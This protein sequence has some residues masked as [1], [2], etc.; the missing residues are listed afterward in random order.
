MCPFLHVLAQDVADIWFVWF[1]TF[2]N[3]PIEFLTAFEPPNT[4]IQ[5]VSMSIFPRGMTEILSFVGSKVYNHSMMDNTE[6]CRNQ[7]PM[8]YS[9]PSF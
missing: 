2:W 1:D 4:N 7:G 6:D 9:I 3:V 8:F 5:L